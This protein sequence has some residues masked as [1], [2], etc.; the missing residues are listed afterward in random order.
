M[1]LIFQSQT[2][3]LF[4]HDLPFFSFTNA[5]GPY[6]TVNVLLSIGLLMFFLA[7]V[8]AEHL[9]V[10]TSCIVC[11]NFC[12]IPHTNEYHMSHISQFVFV[13]SCSLPMNRVS[14]LDHLLLVSLANVLLVACLNDVCM[15]L[16]WCKEQHHSMEHILVVFLESDLW[17][18]C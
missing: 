9:K 6:T 1:C 17:Y 10:S 4:C 3:V 16:L 13:F 8:S 2:M 12:S 18:H 7:V 15:F 11:G 5:N 14:I